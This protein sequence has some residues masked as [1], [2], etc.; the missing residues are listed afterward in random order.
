M[1]EVLNPADLTCQLVCGEWSLMIAL[2]CL[3]ADQQHYHPHH[4]FGIYYGRV[5]AWVVGVRPESL[6]QKL[7]DTARKGKISTRGGKHRHIPLGRRH[8]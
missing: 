7:T 8:D 1:P 6:C 2:G 3:I 5:R 4:F